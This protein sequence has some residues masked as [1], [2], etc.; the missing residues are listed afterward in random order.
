MGIRSIT[1]I[2]LSGLVFTL[3]PGLFQTYVPA[4]W[5]EVPAILFGLGAVSVARHPEGVVT[6]TAQ[7]LR[8]LVSRVQQRI[9]GGSS[10]TGGA[11]GDEALSQASVGFDSFGKV[12]ATP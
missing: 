8:E 1:A 12:E 10:A 4:R 7:Q 3:L 9:R 11:G 2:A 6:Q 5:G